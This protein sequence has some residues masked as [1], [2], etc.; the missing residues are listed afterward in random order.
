MAATK[1]ETVLDFMNNTYN[2]YDI[3]PRENAIT[4]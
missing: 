2:G 3:D 4:L 1:E